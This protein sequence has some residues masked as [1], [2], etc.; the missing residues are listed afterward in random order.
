MAQIRPRKSA[1]DDQR[2]LATSSS[3]WPAHRHLNDA[4]VEKPV[5]PCVEAGWRLVEKPVA[6]CAEAGWRV[7]VSCC[8][9]PQYTSNHLLESWCFLH[10][11]NER[12]DVRAVSVRRAMA[13]GGGG[14]AKLH[15]LDPLPAHVTCTPE[16]P[17]RRLHPHTALR[18]MLDGQTRRD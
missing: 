11:N 13:D 1:L 15:P 16:T 17:P 14:V 8:R 10:Y 9:I 4:L 18:R 7:E 5:A 2:A 12:Q 3:F 6:P